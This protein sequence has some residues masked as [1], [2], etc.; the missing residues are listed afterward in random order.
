MAQFRRRTHPGRVSPSSPHIVWGQMRV[1]AAG[2]RGETGSNLTVRQE[3]KGVKQTEE[4][5]RLHRPESISLYPSRVATR[6]AHYRQP[7]RRLPDPIPDRPYRLAQHDSGH[8]HPPIDAFQ[9]FQHVQHVPRWYFFSLSRPC[10]PL[11]HDSSA[12]QL[13]LSHN[14][15]YRI[16]CTKSLQLPYRLRTGSNCSSMDSIRLNARRSISAS[17][18]WRVCSA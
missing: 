12:L 9:S 18:C 4:R 11:S 14:C 3:R 7:D 10:F 16:K 8:P 13:S 2:Q 17:P 5:V 15:S 1:S 6:R